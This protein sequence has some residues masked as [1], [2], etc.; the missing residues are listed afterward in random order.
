MEKC[1]ILAIGNAIAFVAANVISYLSNT[2]I[3]SGKTI[4]EVSDKYDALFVPAGFTFA[5]WGVIY[6]GLY[7]FVI[8]HLVIAFRESAEHELNKELKT[9][10]WLFVVNNIATAAWV[11]VWIREMLIV[12]VA[13]ILI[14]LITLILIN[15]RLNIYNPA[16]SL[17]SKL[18]TQ[19]PLGIYFAWICIATIAN[20]SSS[21]LGLGWDGGEISAQNW[22][23]ILVAIAA[24]LSLFIILSQRNVFFGLVVIWAL[25]GI[26]SKRQSEGAELY[27][28]II[29]TAWICMALIA[30]VVLIQFVRNIRQRQLTP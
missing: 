27:Q 16:K 2:G 3:F 18:F 8:Y 19:F 28:P 11:V 20:I 21:L 17:G 15:I 23:V 10:G 30:L 24:L 13:L 12:S 4:G 14:Q 29:V 5:V 9:I 26:V 25:Y 7:A 1:R 6:A 22:T